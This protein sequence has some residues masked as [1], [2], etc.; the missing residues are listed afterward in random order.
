MRNACTTTRDKALYEVLESTACRISELVNI[1]KEDINF[2]EQSI[3]VVGKGNK[4]RVVYFSTRAR[5]FLE[6][7][8][9]ERRGDSDIVFLSLKKPYKPLSDRG[10]RFMLNRLKERAEVSE[11]IFPNNFRR[12]KATA[13]LNSG[14]SLQAV[15]QFLGH[16]SP[17]T[18]EIYATISQEN[19]KNE[20]KRLTE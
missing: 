14:M 16:S 9:K 11:R 13:L 19:L 10:V 8:L 3:K 6:K 7:Y 15:Q 18:T 1:K 2:E 4:E 17:V 5:I 20:Y 12:T